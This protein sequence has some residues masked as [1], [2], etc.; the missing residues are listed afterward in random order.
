[1][2]VDPI[3]IKYLGMFPTHTGNAFEHRENINYIYIKKMGETV[4]ICLP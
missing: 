2:Y 3:Q 1:M 4:E